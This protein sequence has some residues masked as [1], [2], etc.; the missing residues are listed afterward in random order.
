MYIHVQ[1][2][3]LIGTSAFRNACIITDENYLRTYTKDSS[4]CTAVC[5]A[6][7][8]IQHTLCTGNVGDAQLVLCRNN[9]PISLSREHKP[10]HAEEKIR[11]EK[12][13][14]FTLSFYSE[15]I[16]FII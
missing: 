13:G 9:L 5:A 8:T 10:A 2:L 11:I 16:C 14:T 12:T 1:A 4:G 7:D 3:S 15:C 6:V